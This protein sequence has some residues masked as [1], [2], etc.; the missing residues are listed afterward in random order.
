MTDFTDLVDLTSERLGGK[1]IAA[2]DEFFAPK[3]NLLNP[4]KPVFLEGK[5]TDRGKWMDGWETR[6]RRTPGYDWCLIRLGLPGIL[7]GVV[8]DTSYF[9]GNF[10]EHF[11]LEACELGDGPPYKN[12][13]TRWKAPGVRWFE[14]LPQTALE[15]DTLS[16][17]PVS[18]SGRFTHL[19]L[20]IYPDGGV[21]RFR[22]YGEVL[23]SA[24]Q[25]ARI[26]I[27]LASV[28]NGGR[29]LESSDQFFSEP[30]NLL[31]PGKS[32]GM[33]DGWETRR[34][35]GTGHDWVIV[36]LGVPG[37]IEKIEV[38]TAHFKG[39][40]PESCSLESLHAG[41]SAQP[42][43]LANS[44]AWKSLLARTPLRPNSRHFY[45]RQL[46]AKTAATHVRF[47][48]FPD[49]GVSRLRLYGRP[50]RPEERLKGLEL[51]NRLP[52]EKAVATFLDCCGSRKWAELMAACRPFAGTAQLFDSADKIWA[53][54]GRK[55]WLAAFRHHPPI[56]GREPIGPQSSKAQQ[57]SK[58]EQSVARSSSPE[59]RRLLARANQAYHAAFGYIF[60]ICAAG[61]STEEILKSLHQRLS[62]DPETEL[63]IATEEQRKITRLRLERLL[64]P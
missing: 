29:I 57:W 8:V 58:G 47:Q 40:F 26:R 45:A 27:D 6:R 51:L 62:N 25:I 60:L 1:V 50:E 23:P 39:N 3:E 54:L 49:G 44:T 20:K 5:Y 19:R 12:E 17:F 36:R 16:H 24:Q 32:V 55:E 4:A 28:E 33:Q 9:C 53:S 2:N 42:A 59:S 35:R 64:G 52:R 10:P 22:A 13:A 14:L 41:P 48:I 31:M 15:G 21:A 34:R 63:V 61:K 11:S 37:V 46:L 43:S 38:D 18:H 7:R 30:L 56:G